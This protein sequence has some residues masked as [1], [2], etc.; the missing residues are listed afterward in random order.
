MAGYAFAPDE[1]VVLRAQEV[2]KENSGFLSS[3]KESELMLTNHNIVYQRKGVFGKV[4]GYDV[5]P[6]SNIRMVDGVPQCR[7]DSSEFMEHK[8][9]VSFADEM[10]TFTFG[11][12]E[13][14][15]EVRAWINQINLLLTGNEAPEENLRASG[16]GAFLEGSAVA[17]SF[18]NILGAFDS[19]FEK[20]KAK[21]A[22]VVASRC[23]SCNASVKGKLGT[24][25]TCPYCDSHVTIGWEQ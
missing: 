11:S 19:A 9:E 13:A 6:L 18:G 15:R 1:K 16:V 7:L 2:S 25:I 21:A 5:Y 22:P 8:L 10:V 14:K 3:M 24:T 12:L 20:A 4:K 17:E 23:P